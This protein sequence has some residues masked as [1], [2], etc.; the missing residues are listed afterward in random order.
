MSM[1]PEVVGTVDEAGGYSLPAVELESAATDEGTGEDGDAED[2]AGI[3]TAAL[4][5]LIEGLLFAAGA[6]VTVARLAEALAGPTRS[7]ILRA[8]QALS[9][10]LVETGRGLR[11]IH[12]AGG[13]QLRTATEHGP[14]VRRLLGQRPARLSRP[15]LETLAIIAY[16]QPATRAEIEAIRGVDVDAVLT[17][18][19]ERRLVHIAGRKETP[20]R[21]L[22]YATT[23]EF[24]EVF[25][26][27]DLAALPPLPEILE[28]AE[29]ITDGDLS[30][31]SAGVRATAEVSGEGVPGA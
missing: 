31:T 7:E 29:V 20:G 25:G 16:R 14:Y 22:L 11:L 24:L 2:R 15:M 1:E 13:Y 9:A 5:P 3:D 18:L 30:V 27:P 12:V 4:V 19:L 28:G 17:T 10:Q 6:P 21:P 8:I 23:R 26:L